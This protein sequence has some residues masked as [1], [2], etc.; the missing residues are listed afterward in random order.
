MLFH[1]TL[2]P[3][4]RQFS[5]IVAPVVDISRLYANTLCFKHFRFNDYAKS[6]SKI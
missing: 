1:L 5:Q 2:R 4:Y 6:V 3:V